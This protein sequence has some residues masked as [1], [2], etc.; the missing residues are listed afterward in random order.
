MNAVK[1]SRSTVGT[2][3]ELSDYLKLLFAKHA[4]LYCRGC[5]NPVEVDN[6]DAI[7]RK[8]VDHK[9][10]RIIVKAPVIVPKNFT[11]DEIEGYLAAQ[12]YDR[13]IR[14]SDRTEVVIDRFD[15]NGVDELRLREAFEAAF[16]VGQGKCSVAPYLKGEESTDALNFS[17]RFH[18]AS[19]N[20]D[21]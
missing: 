18:C 13:F 4:K 1:T 5:A 20:I 17:N 19:C 7:K 3:T 12:G 6:L 10:G 8:L 14:S 15:I 9:L 21:Y 2:M 11:A 16:R